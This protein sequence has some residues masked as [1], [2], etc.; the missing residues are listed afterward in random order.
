MI[1]SASYYDSFTYADYVVNNAWQEIKSCDVPDWSAAVSNSFGKNS[2]NACGYAWT[3]QIRKNIGF[4]ILNDDFTLSYDLLIDKDDVAGTDRLIVEIAPDNLTTGDKDIFRIEHGNAG[5][6]QTYIYNFLKGDNCSFYYDLDHDWEHWVL[7]VD[8]TNSRY[9][10]TIDDVPYCDKSLGDGTINISGI[11]LSASSDN[12]DNN[13]AMLDN[14]NLSSGAVI[15][16]SS[17]CIYPLIFCE[18]F[19]YAGPMMDQDV[20][21]YSEASMSYNEWLVYAGTYSAD[22]YFAPIG[23][24]LLIDSI[25]R[26]PYHDIKWVTLPEPVSIDASTVYYLSRDASAISSEFALNVSDGCFRYKGDSLEDKQVF[27]LEAC[28]S[29]DDIDWDYFDGSAWQNLCTACGTRDSF[30]QVKIINQFKHFPGK[31][32]NSTFT[33]SNTILVINNVTQGN[34]SFIDDNAQDVN[35]FRISQDT[36]IVNRYEL[37]DYYVMFGTDRYTDTTKYTQLPLVSVD[38]TN[39]T[40]ST[41]DSSELVDIIETVYSQV[42]LRS[43]ASRIIFAIFLIIIFTGF[44]IAAGF[45]MRMNGLAI[46]AACVIFDFLLILLFTYLKLIPVWIIIILMIGIAGLAGI[47]LKQGVFTGG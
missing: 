36:D 39:T 28:N 14:L 32:Y 2:S 8:H 38:D 46:G 11:V 23:N 34:I 47:G 13:T 6:N 35:K 4:N 40:L 44:I 24:K 15:P 45:S 41:G 18:P 33:T 1:Y 9:T 29:S 3:N 42:G 43:T 12:A 5:D 20:L 16:D 26:Q 19:D 21:P 27:Y 10:L 37:D 30:D 25:N 22:S 17:L 31:R 7:T